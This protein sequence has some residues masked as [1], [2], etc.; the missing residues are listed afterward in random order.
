MK[1]NVT[2][3][4]DLDAYLKR[5]QWGGKTRPNYDT[6][7]G[8]LGAHMT[9]IPVEN[10]DILLGRPVRLH[11]AD[12]QKKLVFAGRGGNCFQHATLLGVVLEELGFRVARHPAFVPAVASHWN[13]SHSH[14]FLTVRF[15][16]GAYVVDP[17]SGTFAPRVPVPLRDGGQVQVDQESYWMILRRDL[18]TLRGGLGTQRADVW[19]SSLKKENLTGFEIENLFATTHPESPFVNRIIMRALK[20]NGRVTIMNRDLTIWRASTRHTKQLADRTELRAA[21]AEHFG[22]D[23]PEVKRIHVPSIPEWR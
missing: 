3:S 15:A 8:I 12:I 5:V 21:L 14:M 13:Y 7:A 11:I 4:F 1:N 20:K 18:W 19:S 6:L 22:F 9:H 17:G 10:L 2:D 16:E 23:L